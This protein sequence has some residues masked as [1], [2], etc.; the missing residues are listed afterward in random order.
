MTIRQD[1]PSKGIQSKRVNRDQQDLACTKP[2]AEKRD[3]RAAFGMASGA[4]EGLRLPANA[5]SVVFAHGKA[6]DKTD[7]G[8]GTSQ[9][10]NR[11]IEQTDTLSP[12]QSEFSHATIRL[13][14]QDFRAP[15]P[16]SSLLLEVR[17]QA[18]DPARANGWFESGKSRECSRERGRYG[19][20]GCIA[21]EPGG[22]SRMGE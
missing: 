5:R 14:E 21:N 12:H 19:C 18:A 20:A 1:K 22:R 8:N 17:T 16:S 13:V 3:D 6:V 2:D 15:R 10:T 9:E 7:F 11:K 4:P